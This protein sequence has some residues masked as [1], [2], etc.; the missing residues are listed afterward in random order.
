[1]NTQTAE[2]LDNAGVKLTE[3]MSSCARLEKTDRSISSVNSA[4]CLHHW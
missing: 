4:Q 1:M 2:R 3:F